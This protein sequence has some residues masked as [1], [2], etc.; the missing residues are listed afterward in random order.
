MSLTCPNC[1][2]TVSADVFEIHTAHCERFVRTCSCGDLVS[3]KQQQSHSLRRHSLGRCPFCHEVLETWQLENH[4]CP[5]WECPFCSVQL[6]ESQAAEHEEHCGSRTHQ[7][8]TC[9]AFV[10][11]RTWSE[12]E[13]SDCLPVLAAPVPSLPTSQ[14]TGRLRRRR[15]TQWTQLQQ[16]PQ[17]RFKPPPE[18]GGPRGVIDIDDFVNED[19]DLLEKFNLDKLL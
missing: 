9:K 10:K 2:K 8:A 13:A 17:L 11:L 16:I 12:H 18:A 14:S 1:S 7:C 6:A 4:S 3:L 5:V 19:R 15:R